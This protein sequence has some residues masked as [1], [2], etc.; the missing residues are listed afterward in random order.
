MNSI[1]FPVLGLGAMKLTLCV[2][3]V[4]TILVIPASVIAA[5]DTDPRNP[6]LGSWLLDHDASESIGP[7]MKL[8]EA[9]WIARKLATLMTPTITVTELGDNG[10]QIVNEN[11][12]KNTDQRL[13]IDGVERA[14]TDPLGR[15][16]VTSGVWNDNG[17]LAV[18]Q[19]TYVGD[20]RVIVVTSMWVRVNEHIEIVNRAET[21][22]GPLRIRRVFRRKH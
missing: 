18:T 16:V 4:A 12:I 20:D 22:D 21:E 14:E 9:P 13:P 10:V 15:K 1:G 17:Q 19:K 3:I 2:V 11:P 5:D 7:L 6:Y 8:I